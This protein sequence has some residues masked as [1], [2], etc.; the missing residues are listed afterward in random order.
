MPF[1]DAP[2][3]ACPRVARGLSMPC[4]AMTTK[5]ARYCTLAAEGKQGYIA[6]LCDELPPEPVQSAPVSTIP[7]AESLRRQ[8]LA[9]ECE[10]RTD[11]KCGCAGMAT[12]LIGKGKD[13][14]VSLA[15]CV[16]CVTGREPE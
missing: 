16:E 10:H 13:G 12:C 14:Q 7:V 5:H 8:R 15:E 4:Q 2:C 9:R 1:P 11:P 3:A 6:L